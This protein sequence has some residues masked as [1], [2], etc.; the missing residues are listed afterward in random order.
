MD[1]KASGFPEITDLAAI[2]DEIRK[3]RGYYSQTVT[4]VLERLSVNER[5]DVMTLIVETSTSNGKYHPPILIKDLVT[6]YELGVQEPLAQSQKIIEAQDAQLRT[7][8]AAERPN[9]T[10]APIVDQLLRTLREWD[11]LVQPIQLSQRSTGERHNASFEIAGRFRQ[12]A[13]DLFH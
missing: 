9:T 11:R 10:L 4:S 1:R 6:A 13:A 8:A 2:D 7:M 3:Q 12:L 5:V